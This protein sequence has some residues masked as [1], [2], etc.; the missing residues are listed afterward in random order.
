MPASDV[1]A[2]LDGIT[3]PVRR[4]LVVDDDQDSAEGLAMLCR[5]AGHAV[6]VAHDGPTAIEKA[7]SF[8]PEVVVLD[9]GLPGMDGIDTCRELRRMAQEPRPLVIA[10][11]GWGLSDDYDRT[12]TAGFDHHLV[13]PV[14][15][16]Q[17]L[18][19]LSGVQSQDTVGPG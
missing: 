2:R 1:V 3:A 16:Q 13:K 7:K 9:I 6:D 8:R 18:A 14:E 19:M 4:V 15:P 10:V 5:Q 11:T 17:F 12:L